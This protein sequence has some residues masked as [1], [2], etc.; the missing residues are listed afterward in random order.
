M[1]KISR[2]PS[3]PWLE[4]K[5]QHWGK[6][7][8]A[9]YQQTGKSSDFNWRQHKG[10]GKADLV[11][12]LSL[13]TQYH[14]SFCDGY[15]MDSMI[16]ETIEHFRPKTKFP[17]L[18]YQWENLFICSLASMPPHYTVHPEHICCNYCQEKG[19][20]FDENLLKPDELDYDFDTY[21]D[22]DWITGKLLANQDA[23]PE[24]QAKADCT[25]T[26]YKLNGGGR[27]G[28]RMIELKK[29]NSSSLDDLN[30]WSYRYFL[31]RG[32]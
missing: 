7:W 5:W 20:Q 2:L 6:L 23:T 21:F 14:C 30:E 4:E 29:F 9:K 12:K 17:Q 11:E 24:Q 15:P 1:E 22:I 16:Q 28:A 19:D 32:R 8:Q 25:I 10:F 13:M 26:L 31:S 3:P 18:A 27:P